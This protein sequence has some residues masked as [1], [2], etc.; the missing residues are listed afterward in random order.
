LL[1]TVVAEDSVPWDVTAAADNTNKAINIFVTGENGK[2]IDWL[3]EV[4]SLT[5]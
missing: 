4:E 2:T 5:V 3:C 1:R